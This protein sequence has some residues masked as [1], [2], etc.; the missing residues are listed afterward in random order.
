MEVLTVLV[1]S[2]GELM[3]VHDG[4]GLRC[5]HAQRCITYEWALLRRHL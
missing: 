1:L 5:V 3:M 4:I 2:H